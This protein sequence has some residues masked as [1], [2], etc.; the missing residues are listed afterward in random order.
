MGKVETWKENTLLSDLQRSTFM[1]WQVYEA[2]R[3]DNLVGLKNLAC[4]GFFFPLLSSALQIVILLLHWRDQDL[5]FLLSKV[6]NS[7]I[8]YQEFN[9]I[10][11]ID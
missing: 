6:Y 5:T 10:Y 4:C 7:Y 3:D 2:E 8:L 11:P 1:N 9:Y